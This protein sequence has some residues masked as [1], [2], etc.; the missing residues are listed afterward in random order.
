MPAFAHAMKAK[1]VALVSGS[2]EKLPTVAA[3]YGIKPE[4]C[5]EDFDR[6]RKNPEVKV[7]HIVLPKAMHRLYAERAARAGEH[8]L[9]EKPM[10]ITCRD[11]QAMVKTCKA[12]GVKLMV[13]YRVQYEPYN[14]RAQNL[15]HLSGWSLKA[16]VFPCRK[17]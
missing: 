1:P 7:V 6:I 8:V 14:R 10:S 5:Y 15:V 12:A 2:P 11:G 13:A 4:A 16:S 17:R 9:T 3:Q